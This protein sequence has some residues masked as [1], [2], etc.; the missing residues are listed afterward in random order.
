L[1]LVRRRNLGFTNRSG[2]AALIV[3]PYVNAAAPY[4]PG[5]PQRRDI[6]LVAFVK[7]HGRVVDTLLLVGVALLIA[8]LSAAAALVSEEHHLSPA[9]LLALWA[10]IGFFII[11]GRTYG[12]RKFRSPSFTLF[13]I[14]WLLMHVCV[15][16]A[17]LAYF[18]F[19]YYLPFL[20]AELFIG[21]MAAIWLFGPPPD[22][23]LY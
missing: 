1:P 20:V 17:V 4:V 3:A 23:S 11:I 7:K 21:F 6:D 16:L 12:V 19:L 14:A 5:R 22:R 13:S 9:W 15:F 8:A 2:G 10:G 18:G